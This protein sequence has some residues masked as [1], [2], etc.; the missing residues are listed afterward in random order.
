MPTHG[1]T[2]NE[3]N[4]RRGGGLP[5]IAPVVT[6]IALIQTKLAPSKAAGVEAIRLS[7]VNDD[8]RI[9]E[10]DAHEETIIGFVM[11]PILND[12]RKVTAVAV[13]QMGSS[14]TPSPLTPAQRAALALITNEL[15]DLEASVAANAFVARDSADAGRAI[16]DILALIS[17]AAAAAEGG[18]NPLADAVCVA[19]FGRTMDGDTEPSDQD[20]SPVIDVPPSDEDPDIRSS[21]TSPDDSGGGGDSGPSGGD[22]SGDDSGGDT[23][24]GNVEH[25]GGG[26]GGGQEDEEIRHQQ[27]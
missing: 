7:R 23:G 6:S 20:G 24:D 15:K 8:L 2:G 1:L 14:V 25:D 16:D 12:A 21:S 5:D 26:G 10:L 11:H 18:A 19:S 13:T 22:G 9:E 3:L 27:E 4:L 17:C